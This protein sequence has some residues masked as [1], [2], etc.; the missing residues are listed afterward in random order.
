MKVEIEI[1]TLGDF[2]ST[3]RRQLKMRLRDVEAKTGI[4]LATVHM[5]EHGKNI[6]FFTG[7]KLLA[8]YGIT[9]EEARQFLENEKVNNKQLKK[10]SKVKK[11]A[12]WPESQ[13]S[14]QKI[15]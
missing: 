9:L 2:M 6:K 5:A 8:F 7:I 14:R 4:P 12:S 10:S 15:I 1:N 3:K 11:V 13:K